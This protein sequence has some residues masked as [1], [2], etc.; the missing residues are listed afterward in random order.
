MKQSLTLLI[1]ALV[2]GA[3]DAVVFKGFEYAV[4]HGTQY[5]WN[6]IFKTDIHRW[7]V[8]PLALVLGLIL[9]GLF[10]AL[11]QHRVVTPKINSVEEETSSEQPTINGLITIAIIG[12]ASLLAGASLGPEASLVALCGGLG[13]WFAYR[14]HAIKSV[15][16]FELASVGA[17]LVVF[18][19]AL[20]MILLPLA[21]L[22]KKKQLSLTYA[23]IILLSG[24]SAYGVLWLMDRNTKGYGTI[25]VPNHFSALDF[26]LAAILGLCTAIL[27]WLLKHFILA[28]NHQIV[29]WDKKYSW[30][31]TGS[32]FG[33]VVGF[34][35]LVGGESVQFSGSNGSVMLINH[36]PA[37]SIAML[38]IIL[39]A[40]LLVTGWSLASGYRGGLVFPS[41]FI[42]VSIALIAEGITGDISSGIMVGS[43]AGVFSALIGPVPA[44]IF[45]VGLLPF[46]L[47][48][49]SI[50]GITFAVLGNKFISRFGQTKFSPIKIKPSH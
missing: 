17:L 23:A 32:I 27:G 16:L 22:I 3:L 13:A 10:I 2:I 12:I 49:I 5:I 48:G 15:P 47:I 6:D 46:K 31:L 24:V 43:I 38:I 40:K 20:V 35:Y 37:F 41:I 45:M 25:P 29:I 1:T 28:I 18:V 14:T 19:G 8:I 42:G 34:L 26:I 39:V 33:L 9:S 50:V 44:F 30:V 4:N 36:T 21:M 11:K 7:L